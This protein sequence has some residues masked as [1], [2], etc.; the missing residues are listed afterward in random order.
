MNYNYKYIGEYK[1]VLFVTLFLILFPSIFFTQQ[2]ISAQGGTFSNPST[3]I[4]FTIGEIVIHTVSDGTNELTQGFHQTNW[5]FLGVED[6]LEEIQIKLYPNPASEVLIVNT[7]EFKDL[8]F[9]MHNAEG[10]I[11][12][13][14]ELVDQK[15]EINVLYISPG[16]Y[17]LTF[18]NNSQ[19]CKSFKLLK[20]N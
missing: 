1:C 6:F 19:I 15:T 17:T 11:V 14:G 18:L 9:E 16:N 13:K 4:D 20:S 10:K 3:N 7:S 12:L 2:V 5:S 8:S